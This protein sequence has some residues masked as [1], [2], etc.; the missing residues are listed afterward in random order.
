MKAFVEL[1]IQRKERKLSTNMLFHQKIRA[2][3]LF[4]SKIRAG[5]SDGYA[6]ERR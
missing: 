2:L 3:T 5:N 6:V 4:L 1:S